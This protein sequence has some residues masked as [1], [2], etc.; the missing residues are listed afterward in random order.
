MLASARDGT[1][2]LHPTPFDSL[3]QL[4]DLQALQE[5]YRKLIGPV[6]SRTWSIVEPGDAFG[7]FALAFLRS[8]RS[9]DPKRG[10]EFPTYALPAIKQ[11]IFERN[12]FEAKRGR[13]QSQTSR[14]SGP[15][16]IMLT[17]SELR[18]IDI[19]G[20]EAPE[21]ETIAAPDD[22]GLNSAEYTDVHKF[23]D[24]LPRRQ[25]QVVH[26]VYWEGMSPAEAARTLGITRAAV[27]DL[28]RKV[29][30]RGKEALAS[31]A[32]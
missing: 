24:A 8:R 9:F 3:Q 1:F 31:Y 7:D 6:L 4:Q 21:W 19:D 30:A 32:E 12:R 13:R 10:V 20:D 2:D 14:S 28:L 11:A 22:P 23:V 26:L 25:R 27:N 16:R 15:D 17:E 29:R 5:H 18:T